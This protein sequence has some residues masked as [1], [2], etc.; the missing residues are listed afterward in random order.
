MRTVAYSAV[1]CVF[2]LVFPAALSTAG[3]AL[4]LAALAV[5]AVA[6]DATAPVVAAPAASSATSATAAGISAS[7]AAAS[8]AST[9]TIPVAAVDGTPI[10]IREVEDA[11]LKQEGAE[12]VE[13]WVHEQ[14][15]GTDWAN[16]Q[17][18]AVVLSINDVKI[19]RRQLALALLKSR[20]GNAREDLIA[21]TL[22]KQALKS[23][24]V[25]IDADIQ[26]LTYKR[27]ERAFETEL[28]RKGQPHM[29]FATYLASQEKM[30]P[31]QFTAQPG[32]RM[33]AGIQALIDRRAEML[34][35]K[36]FSDFFN[37]HHDIYD[38]PETVQ[39]DDIFVPYKLSKDA[40]GNAVV[41]PDEKDAMLVEAMVPIWH[42]IN[43]GTFTFANRWNLFGRGWDSD[44]V[45]G[46]IGWV[47]RDG[48][49]RD[50]LG[51]MKIGARK[52]P[53]EVMSAAFKVAHFPTLL[54]PITSARG[55]DIVRID[56][57]RDPHIATYAEAKQ[58]VFHDFIDAHFDEFK[59]S[60]MN[61]LRRRSKI[62]Y[63]DL[64]A[65]EAKRAGDA[66]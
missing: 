38:L 2:S 65:A 41:D 49:R 26:V 62:D 35:E 59:D 14:L 40:S 25:V 7:A 28:E 18:D 12:Q 36:T 48:S 63:L 10:T 53:D 37:D 27:M 11:L 4:M 64:P 60:L 50:D 9:A 16:L 19:T 34:P 31:E 55:I 33:L 42:D 43:A 20:A 21:L 66:P 32:F 47:A 15:D 45:D 22:V 8:D 61:E 46:Y 57:H 1:S 6:A 23:E 39:M 29:E 24:G 13:K 52:L 44:A 58:R 30:T 5:P 56:G 54:Q 17:E 51:I 3:A